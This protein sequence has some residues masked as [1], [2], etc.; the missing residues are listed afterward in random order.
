[1]VRQLSYRPNYSYTIA[2]YL[3][4]ILMQLNI[5]SSAEFEKL[6]QAL[7][8]EVIHANFFHNLLEKLHFAKYEYIR[9]FNQ[10]NAFWGMTFQ[11]LT[12]AAL[13]RLCRV[14]D[15][16]PKAINLPNLLDTIKANLHIFG[17]DDFRQRLKDNPYVDSLSQGARKPDVA[18]L[19][20]D[21]DYVSNKNPLVQKLLIWR[22]NILAHRNA[23]NVIK[24]R[25]LVAEYPFSLKD[26]SDLL[27]RGTMILNHYNGLFR[28]VTFSP[29]MV[30]HDD[31]IYVLACMRANSERLE[32]D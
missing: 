23:G 11:A 21:I 9:E 26:M 3:I 1:M 32:E 2:Q 10:A 30:G 12:D 5:K 20:N 27:G 25:N 13:I 15:T 29:Q 31:Y 17:V 19:N 8:D 6:L 7:A 14:Y 18:Q 4:K 16:H 28:A 24:D 22:G